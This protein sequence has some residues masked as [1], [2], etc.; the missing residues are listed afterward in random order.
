MGLLDRLKGSAKP[1]IHLDGTRTVDLTGPQ[2]HADTL[3]KIVKRN[4]VKDG[5]VPFDATLICEKRNPHD[6]NAVAVHA[7]GRVIGYLSRENAALYR[8]SLDALMSSGATVSADGY[9]FAG[10]QG[11]KYWSVGVRM[12]RPNKM[13]TATAEG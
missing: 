5:R 4:G 7:G 1:T 12:P 10:H 2:H 3:R 9:I 11:G 8:P 6:P 13:P